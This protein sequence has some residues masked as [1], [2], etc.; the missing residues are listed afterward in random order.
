MRILC[1]IPARSG[2]KGIPDKNIKILNNK[3]LLCHSIEQ[4]Q[5]S[6]YF[7]NKQM[8]V[9]VSTDSPNYAKI[10]K[11]NGAEIPILRPVEIAGDLSTDYE[12]IKHMVDHLV[13]SEKYY[14]DIILQLRPT[15]PIRKVD[16][17]DKCLDIFI[18]KYEEFDSLRT[19]VPF[20]K[21]PIKMYKIVDNNLLPFF[22]FLVLEDK[23]MFEPFNQPRQ[24]LPQSFLHNGY[25]DILKAS[26][27][28]T[29]GISG[30]KIYPYIMNKED[31]IDI[32]TLEDWNKCGL[33]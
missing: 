12:F 9:I 30:N 15:Q 21:S 24:L 3:P 28:E 22:P 20:E 8:R 29:G 16:D 10:A 18:E 33:N 5:K 2:S 4:A 14:P 27:L 32:D 6:K 23:I 13:E 31:T 26:I 11:D 17:I 25:I 19:V 1:I 7:I